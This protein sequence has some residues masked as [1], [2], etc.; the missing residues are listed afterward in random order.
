MVCWVWVLS[1]CCL[2]G[3]VRILLGFDYLGFGV[4]LWACLFLIYF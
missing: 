1:R 4:L 3:F 2:E